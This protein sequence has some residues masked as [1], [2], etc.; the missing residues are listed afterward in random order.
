MQHTFL[1]ISLP[2]FCKS[3]TWNFQELLSYKFY[4]GNVVRVLVHFFFPAAYFNFALVAS[5]ISY[6]LTAATKVSCCSSKKKCRL[7]C[8]SLA[9]DFCRPF[10]RYASL[11]C[12]LLSPFLCLPLALFSKFVDMTINL[13]LLLQTTRIQKQFPL[14]VFVF[15]DSLGVSAWQD[16]GGYAIS[17][18]NNLELYLGCHTCWLSY[19]TLI[20]LWCGRT[21]GGGRCTV[22]WFPNILRWVDLLTY[23]APLARASRARELRYNF[24]RVTSLDKRVSITAMRYTLFE[25][26]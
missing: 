21:V 17:R 14:S 10:S 6:F 22:M 8:S 19:F 4:G 11:A 7:C 12:R 15:I 3:T 9:L 23:G 25:T 18:Q 1:Y 26:I 16:S 5:S 13:S 2:L 20:Y 24:Q